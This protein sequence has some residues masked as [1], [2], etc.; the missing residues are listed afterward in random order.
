MKKIIMTTILVLMSAQL[1]AAK[2]ISK[3]DAEKILRET[4]ATTPGCIVM[5]EFTKL[6]IAIIT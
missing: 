5:D 6:P 4:I 2:I 3:E 1:Y